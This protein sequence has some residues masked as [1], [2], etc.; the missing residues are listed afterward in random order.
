ML[1]SLVPYCCKK[2]L[3]MAA[4]NPGSFADLGKDAKEALFKSKDFNLKDQV[5]VATNSDGLKSTAKITREEAGKYVGQV[6]FK[7]PKWKKTGVEGG[8][9]FDSKGKTKLQ[10]SQSDRLVPGLKLAAVAELTAGETPKRELHLS[11]EY[12]NEYLTNNTKLVVPFSSSGPN[13]NGASVISSLVLARNGITGGAE[14]NYGLADHSLK[15]L[16]DVIQYKRD[17]FTLLGFYNDVREGKDKK[18]TCGAIYHQKVPQAAFDNTDVTG[19]IEYDLVKN[20]EQL[21]VSLALGLDVNPSF[22]V[23]AKANSKGQ[24]TVIFT[25]T[26]NKNTKV[27]LG[28]ELAY[29]N[30][31]ISK[32]FLELSFTD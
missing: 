21:T 8:A 11:A 14:I 26:L 20:T 16:Q 18:H 22:R 10:I 24:T 4:A 25:N 5:S 28:G 1:S 27:R 13:L 12:K 31:A 3:H 19:E 6:E 15:A 9:T 30:L 7:F 29:D 32:T 17:S 2:K 23:N